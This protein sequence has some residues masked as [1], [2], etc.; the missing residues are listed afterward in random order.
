LVSGR[1][2]QGASENGD[3]DSRN[4]DNSRLIFV[5]E[6]TGTNP[7]DTAAIDRRHEDIGRTFVFGIASIVFASIGYALLKRK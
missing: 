1:S 5:D 4:G 7:Y 3:Q 6:R 2:P